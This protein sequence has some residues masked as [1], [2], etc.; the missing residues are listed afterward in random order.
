MSKFIWKVR[1]YVYMQRVCGWSRWEIVN[2]MCETFGD[3]SPKDAVD[4]E[5]SYWGD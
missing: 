3:F 4:E 5:L 1:A 2:S